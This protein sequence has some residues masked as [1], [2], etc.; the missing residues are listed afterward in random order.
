MASATTGTRRTLNNTVAAVFGGVYLLVGLVGFAVSGGHPVAGHEGGML[1]GVFEVNVLHNLV[2]IAIGVALLL[3]GLRGSERAAATA[4]TTVGAA[5]L[6][7]F[8]YG[9]V[10]PMSSAANIVALNSA[11]N[12]LHLLSALLLGGVGL[13]GLRGRAARA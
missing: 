3:A 8:V 9:L 4:N 6:V 12:V 2:H 7:V 13:A 1:L 11:D 5:Y 10:V